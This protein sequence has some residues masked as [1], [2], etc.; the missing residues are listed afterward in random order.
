[1]EQTPKE[2]L[3]DIY[4][5]LNIRRFAEHYFGKSGSWL[6]HKFDQ[7]DVNHNGNTDDFTEEQLA[8]LKAGL[9]DFAE[10]IK[11]AADTL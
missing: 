4:L 1:M 7:A 6:Y 8:T 11:A 3:K 5:D 10:R 9:Y 2:K